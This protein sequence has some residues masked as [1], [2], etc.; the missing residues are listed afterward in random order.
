MPR[1]TSDVYRIGAHD[2]ALPYLADSAPLAI[3]EYP[4]AAGP[5][6]YVLTDAGALRAVIEAKKVGAVPKKF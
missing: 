1:G 2:P 4:T 5:A 3:A 6:D